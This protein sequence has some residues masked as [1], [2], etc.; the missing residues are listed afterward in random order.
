MKISE[1]GVLVVAADLKGAMEAKAMGAKALWPILGKPMAGYLLKTILEC[2][3]KSVFVVAGHEDD[4]LCEYLRSF[5]SVTPIK[6]DSPEYDEWGAVRFAGERLKQF[7]HALVLRCDLPFLSAETI[8][9][10]VRGH[11]GSGADCS[12]LGDAPYALA[13]SPGRL[14][15]VIDDASVTLAGLQGAA[16]LK[17]RKIALD[18]DEAPVIRNQA[19]LAGTATRM[20]DAIVR[21]WMEKG[22][23]VM[24]PCAVWIGPDAELEPGVSLMPGVQIWGNSSVGEGSVIGPYCI[25]RDAVLGREVRLISN[26]VVEDSE[27]RDH[28]KAGPF[29]Y[30]RE[31]SVLKEHAFAGRFVELKKTSVGSDSKVPH[32]SYMGD[33]IL[34]E[35]VN[36]GAGSITC[37]FDGVNKFQTKI[38]DRCFVG[39]DTMMVAPVTLGD[40]SMTGA[41]STITAD[42]PPGA[43][44]V[45]RARQRNLEGWALKKRLTGKR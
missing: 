35:S 16:G 2:E 43:L 20:R 17:T 28:V 15:G 34:G 10:F 38:G 22:V 42:V 33:A 6:L 13:F 8:R 26:V 7:P 14:S 36:I 37:N 44:A 39:S 27:L 24:D 21:K 3:P 41:G 25:L 9:L 30:I 40:D 4:A 12:F 19:E 1:F 29:A 45:G 18:A 5:P 11:V 23:H 31:D 32:L